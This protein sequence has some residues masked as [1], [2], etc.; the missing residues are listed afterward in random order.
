M[1]ER[2]P[3][4][5]IFH[6]LKSYNMLLLLQV[7]EQ[8]KKKKLY[9]SRTELASTGAPCENATVRFSDRRRCGDIPQWQRLT[10]KNEIWQKCSFIEGKNLFR[11]RG[12]FDFF[13]TFSGRGTM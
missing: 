6:E 5:I 7:S 1:S 4:T 3:Y 13:K 8:Q 10:K 9:L 11:F 12:C 2:Q